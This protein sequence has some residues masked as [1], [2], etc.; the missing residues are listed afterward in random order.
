MT[1]RLIHARC[2]RKTKRAYV[3]FRDETIGGDVILVAIF[4]FRRTTI[5]TKGVLEQELAMK[6]RRYIGKASTI[7]R[8]PS[9]MPTMAE[10]LELFIQLRR[11]GQFAG[12]DPK[13][14]TLIEAALRT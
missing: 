7:V 1:F 3:E 2:D 11:S 9:Y 10:A 8:D 12:V 6:A 14:L 4:P 5:L 13:A